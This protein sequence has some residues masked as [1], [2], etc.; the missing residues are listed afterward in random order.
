VGPT[1]HPSAFRL[2]RKELAEI[3]DAAAK[4]EADALEQGVAAEEAKVMGEAKKRELTKQKQEERWRRSREKHAGGTGVAD[5][6]VDGGDAGSQAVEPADE[7]QAD[8]LGADEPPQ[9]PA[10]LQ[11]PVRMAAAPAAA[12]GTRKAAG[13]C[14]AKAPEH[15]KSS[16]SAA[17]ASASSGSVG[18]VPTITINNQYY[19][20]LG[21][22]MNQILKHRIFK[23]ILD[24][25]PMEISADLAKSSGV[26]ARN[27]HVNVCFGLA[28]THWTLASA[29]EACCNNTQLTTRRKL[30]CHSRQLHQQLEPAPPHQSFV[31]TC[32]SNYT[33]LHQ[34]PA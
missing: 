5:G 13:P 14:V 12:A 28:P 21:D 17:A 24:A 1:K 8:E 15:R 6:D 2:Y 32:C 33:V 30:P 31:S 23:G 22:A 25:D 9:E 16:G 3:A 7:P 18:R 20:M 34:E 10:E 27:P 26:Q 11:E 19:V 4:V 29:T